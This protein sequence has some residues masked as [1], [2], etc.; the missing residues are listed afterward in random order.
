MVLDNFDGIESSQAFDEKAMK[1]DVF[2]WALKNCETISMYELDRITEDYRI[3]W[4]R[5]GEAKDALN[6]G[7]HMVSDLRRQLEEAEKEITRLYSDYVEAKQEA[8]AVNARL[9]ITHD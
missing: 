6:R 2:M 5:V 4:S 1:T 9:N 7:Q 8:E 3:S